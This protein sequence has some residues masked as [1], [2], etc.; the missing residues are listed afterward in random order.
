MSAI[1]D[2]LLPSAAAHDIAAACSHCL[3]P[4]GRLGQRRSVNGEELTFCCY[5]CC[6]AYQVRH[7]VGEEH[8]A[9]WLLVRLGVG[10]FRALNIM[11]LSLLIYT[12]SLGPDD[13]GLRQAVH[14]LLGLLA[15]P[16]LVFL[17]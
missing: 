13:A 15:T 7:G 12:G 9:A 1:G 17:G 14:V 16:V 5:G 4:I 2:S 11:L 6:I 8:E 3:L 10:A